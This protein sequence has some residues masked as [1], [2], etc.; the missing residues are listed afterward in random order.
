MKLGEKRDIEPHDHWRFEEQEARRE[1]EQHK[2][3]QEQAECPHDEHDHYICLDCGKDL[4]DDMI[5]RSD[6]LRDE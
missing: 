1:Y 3:E 5:A 6:L 4:L 2:R